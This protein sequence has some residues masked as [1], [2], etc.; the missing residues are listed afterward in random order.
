MINPYVITSERLGLRNWQAS[1]LEPFIEMG[2]DENVMKYFPSLLSEKETKVLIEKFQLH[3]VNYGYTYFAIDILETSEFIGFTGFVHQTWE[4]KFTPCIDIG[5]R[6][7]KSAWGK[8]YAS[9]AANCCFENGYEKFGINE[10]YAF[11]SKNNLD[12]E[13]VMQ[14]IQMEYV[15]YFDSPKL[16]DTPSLNPCMVY[17]KEL[18]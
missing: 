13:N 8:G 6:I 4:S 17:K 2:K 12:S 1:D 7:K 14:K 16:K 5:W 18:I 3:F 9:E 10:V 15:D 11:A